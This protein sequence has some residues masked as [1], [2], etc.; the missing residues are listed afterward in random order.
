MDIPITVYAEMTPNP[1]TLKFV[2]NKMLVKEGEILEFEN[3][4][5]SMLYS[6]LATALFNFPFVNGIFMTRNFVSI[7]KNEAI[8][9]DDISYE[10]RIFITDYLKENNGIAV[11][12]Y[13]E[14]KIEE[15]NTS[16]SVSKNLKVAFT[17]KIETETDQQ[18]V[19]LLDEYVRPAVEG[20]GGAI[21][22]L[23]NDNGVVKVI[24]R[25]ACSGCPSSM[26]TLKGGVEQLLKAHI[27]N[28]KE[29]VAVEG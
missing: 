23:S 3:Q 11:E 14:V 1:S 15:S 19:D 12:A 21:D 8:E 13:P 18:I 4:N 6:G 2:A 7:T 10:L 16:E 25:G 9:W 5:E 17:P 22:F 24:L 26:E 27:P 29:V 28:V 20:D